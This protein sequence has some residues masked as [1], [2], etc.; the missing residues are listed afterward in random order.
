MIKRA[1]FQHKNSQRPDFAAHSAIKK[2]QATCSILSVFKKNSDQL[3]GC[4]C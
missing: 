1:L 4:D 3:A 2:F